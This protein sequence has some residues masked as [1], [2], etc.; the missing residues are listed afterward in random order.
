VFSAVRFAVTPAT[1]AV[2]ADRAIR[3]QHCGSWACAGLCHPER[4]HRAPGVGEPGAELLV[5][6]FPP[7]IRGGRVTDPPRWSNDRGRIEDHQ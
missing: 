3:K 2:A 1:G 5:D 7:E 6:A 4:R